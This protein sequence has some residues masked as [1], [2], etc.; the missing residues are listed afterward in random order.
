LISSDSGT[1]SSY[2]QASKN[3]LQVLAAEFVRDGD[4]I[5]GSDVAVSVAV[6]VGAQNVEEIVIADLRRKACNV[7]RRAD[8][9]RC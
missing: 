1:S 3:S 7:N 8:R 9:P 5:G 4:E 2:S 6:G